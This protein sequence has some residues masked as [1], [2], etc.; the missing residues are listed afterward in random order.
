LNGGSALHEIIFYKD[1]D[2]NEPTKTYIVN[3]GLMRGKDSRIKFNK[4][5]DYLDLLSERGMVIGEPYIKHIEGDIWEI[6]PLSDRIFFVSWDG[7]RFLMLHHFV[8]KA[9]K[10]PQREINTAKRRLEK[11]RSEAKRYEQE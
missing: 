1:N 8:K 4:I 2:G 5:M 3:L 9:Q 7:D 6:R 11:A 10:T